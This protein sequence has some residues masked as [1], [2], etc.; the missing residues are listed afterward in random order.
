VTPGLGL[1]LIVLGAAASI[2]LLYAVERW[3]R[4]PGLAN[5][6][7]AIGLVAAAALGLS[8]GRRL[9]PILFLLQAPGFLYFAWF[10]RTR[11]GATD[12]GAAKT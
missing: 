6:V 2:L 11:R 3:L 4:Q 7:V 5:L 8:D 10:R 9:V 1:L 12:A